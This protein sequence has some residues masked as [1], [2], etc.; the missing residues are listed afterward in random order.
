MHRKL[1]RPASAS[2]A[3]STS[4]TGS[5]AYRAPQSLSFCG[6]G[7]DGIRGP[8]PRFSEII[9][10]SAQPRAQPTLDLA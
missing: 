7:A 4:Q 2:G 5:L 10:P 8:A 9:S 3:A 1:W 6:G